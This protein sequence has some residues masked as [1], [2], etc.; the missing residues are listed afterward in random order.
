MDYER[1]YCVQLVG[2]RSLFVHRLD[3]FEN[4]PKVGDAL[5]I[6]YINDTQKAKVSFEKICHQVRKIF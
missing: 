4:S 6:S 2:Q 1:G 5:R 3:K